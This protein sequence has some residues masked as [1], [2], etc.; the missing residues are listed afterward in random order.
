MKVELRLGGLISV[1]GREIALSRTLTLL[2]GVA[3]ERSVRG[4]ADRLGLSYRS[5]WGRIV[6][7]EEAIGRPLVVK[8]KGHGSVLTALGETL[9]RS[10]QVTLKHFEPGLALEQ[11]ALEQR[12]CDLVGASPRRLKIAA[13]HDPFL[14]KTLSGHGDVEV[15]VM[16]SEAAL[17]L[18]LSGQVDVAGCH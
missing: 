10:L 2:E 5:A 4:A 18:L 9:R 7:L 6:A 1:N 8:T 3:E 12:L 11:Q 14:L 16:G 15:S 13:S 17:D